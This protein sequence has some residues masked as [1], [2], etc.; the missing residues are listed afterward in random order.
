MIAAAVLVGFGIGSL[1]MAAFYERELARLGAST[2]T[3]NRDNA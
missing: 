1:L 2:G 3:P